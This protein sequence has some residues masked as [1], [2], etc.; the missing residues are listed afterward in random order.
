MFKFSEEVYINALSY[1][2]G[3]IKKNCFVPGKIENWV[4][5]MDTKKL[6]L[7]KFPFKVKVT[8]Y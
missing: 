1:Y 6:G 3:I 5:I 2:F 4:F 8:I 7:S